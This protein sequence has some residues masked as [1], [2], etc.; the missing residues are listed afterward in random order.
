MDNFLNIAT[1]AGGLAFFLFGMN[2]LGSGLEKLSG[3]KM[4]KTLEK[5]TNNVFKSLLLG[6]VVTAAIQSS[7]ATT[8]IVVGLVNA[9]ILKLRNAIGVI[10]GA[11]IGT[12][13][14]S[15][16]LSL[17]DLDQSQSAGTLLTLLKPTS[18]TPIIAIVGIIILM[19]AKNGKK[20]II[21]EILLGFGILFN[22]M[23]IMTDA[24]APMADSPF[25]KT[26]FATLSNPLLGVLAGALVTA[27]IQSS[28][29]SVGILQAVASTGAVNFSAA[30]PIIMG[31][32]IG[33]CVTSLLSSIGANKNARRAAMVHLY[34]N[35]IGTILFF[36]A[37]YSLKNLV[38]FSFWDTPI[39]M[40][41]ISM[42][43]IIFNVVTTLIFI[44][45]TR[46]LERLAVWTVRDR[47]P[48]PGEEDEGEV[49]AIVLEERLLRSPG[50]ALGQCAD[51]IKL[52]GEYARK[53]FER[54]V[55]LFTKYD[56]RRKEKINEYENAI[57]HME[58]KLNNYLIEL[59]NSELTD[60]ES[61]EVTFQLKL[62]LEFERIGDYAINVMELAD[63]LHEKQAKLSEK[64]LGELAAI[65]DAVDE[66]IGM[67]VSAFAENNL[68]TA[69]RIEPL[70]ETIDTME[71]TLKFRHVERLKNGK[72]TID[73][74]LVFL[75]LLTNL[76]RISDHCSNVAVYIIGFNHNKESLDRH[77]YLKH[78]H[79][80]EAND[81]NQTFEYYREKYFSRIERKVEQQS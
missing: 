48:A 49:E 62:V 6:I 57:D 70:E 58:D 15:I 4:E 20:K 39:T 69:T 33:T 14:T 16:I 42:V 80:G 37:V 77:E 38:G 55:R 53:N 18:W 73:G 23:F 52:M 41:G 54:S 46:F 65:S 28:S 30:F 11:N 43:H 24:V 64:A 25:F 79:G 74:G 36:V 3:G 50:L 27:I 66:I 51:A 45:F 60:E 56:A 35:V 59:T 8:V 31:Q 13:V 44:P 1:M 40:G 17:G 7:S 12:T 68:S 5:M 29:A 9:G 22:G 34:F 81:Y 2:I 26:L 76:E 71:D 61:R 78:L 67:A 21:G 47:K 75:E 19:T 32:N 10:M 72:C 63:N